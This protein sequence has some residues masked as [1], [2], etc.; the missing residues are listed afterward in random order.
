[1]PDHEANNAGKVV[2]HSFFSTDCS[3]SDQ[4]Q[5]NLALT[6]KGSKL[7]L[8]VWDRSSVPNILCNTENTKTK[9]IPFFPCSK[10]TVWNSCHILE[11]RQVSEWENTHIQ[12]SLLVRVIGAIRIIRIIPPS[13]IWMVSD[14]VCICLNE[15][16]MSVM[17]ITKY[18]KCQ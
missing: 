4:I 10:Y 18:A 5:Q 12:L 17:L 16:G 14:F 1:M 7:T 9:E 6:A 15:E 2:F 3:R 11:N 13:C 8:G